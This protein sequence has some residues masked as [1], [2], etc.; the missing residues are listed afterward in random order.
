M[1][2]ERNPPG[3]PVGPWISSPTLVCASHDVM[4]SCTQPACG[5]PGTST[6]LPSGGSVCKQ[7][8]HMGY[9][10][11]TP[12]CFSGASTHL[13]ARATGER[14]V[15]ARDSAKL[16]ACVTVTIQF[17][18]TKREWKAEPCI[19]DSEAKEKGCGNVGHISHDDPFYCSVQRHRV[20]TPDYSYTCVVGEPPRF[21][22]M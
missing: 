10:A 11:G 8:V 9:T 16:A 18:S 15:A 12:R 1:S 20:S 21:V 7:S 3:P 6:E 19:G 22:V 2:T 17:G 5:V 4:R 14:P 13:T